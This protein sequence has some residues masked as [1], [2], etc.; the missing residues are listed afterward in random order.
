MLVMANRAHTDRHASYLRT[1]APFSF[2][3]HTDPH[4]CQTSPSQSD[5]RCQTGAARLRPGAEPPTPSQSKTRSCCCW[6]C[7]TSPSINHPHRISSPAPRPPLCTSSR[8]G[9]LRSLS[10]SVLCASVRPHLLAGAPARFAFSS[11]QYPHSSCPR[12][13]GPRLIPPGAARTDRQSSVRS[14]HTFLNQSA[15]NHLCRKSNCQA[16]QST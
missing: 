15:L 10:L 6:C 9:A 7:C 3:A 13:R 14:C 12:R 8:A 5:T 1:R 11:P 16:R 4:A 2:L